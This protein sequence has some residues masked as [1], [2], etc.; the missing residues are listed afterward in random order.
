[1]HSRQ[2][3][4]RVRADSGLRER[5]RGGCVEHRVHLHMLLA[6][7]VAA[8]DAVLSAC[9]GLVVRRLGAFSREASVLAERCGRSR[10]G[11]ER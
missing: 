1:M 7:A 6:Y 10:V 2:L 5:V 3:T 4:T 8:A 9:A 11:G